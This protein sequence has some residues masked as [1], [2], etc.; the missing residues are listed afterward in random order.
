[1][2]LQF[3]SQDVLCNINYDIENWRKKPYRC[4]IS[5]YVF[6]MSV[7]NFNYTGNTI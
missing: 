7:N 3:K 4:G 2:A 1:M 5:W 6:K